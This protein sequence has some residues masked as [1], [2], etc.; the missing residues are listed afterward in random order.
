VSNETDSD[1]V[2]SVHVH[3]TVIVVIPLPGFTPTVDAT[4]TRPREM[5]TTPGGGP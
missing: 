5:F 1:T 3:A 4:V 2:V